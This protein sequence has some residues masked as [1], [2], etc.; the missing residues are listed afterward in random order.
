MSSSENGLE[1]LIPPHEPAS[2]ALITVAGIAIDAI[3]IIGPMGTRALDHALATRD[4]ERRLEF[5]RAV[6]AELQR[7]ADSSLT[8]GDVV[9]SDEFLAALARGQRVAAEASSAAKRTRL[10]AAVAS[11]VTDKTLSANERGGFWRYVEQYDDLHIWLLSFFSSP[12]DWLDAHG[13]SAAHERIRGGTVAEPLT[14][15]LG[16]DPRSTP[17]VRDAIEELQR[18]MMLGA[19]D[20]NTDRSDRGQFS[21]QTTNRGRRFLA[22]LH[23]RAPHTAETPE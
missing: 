23:E 8:V 5:D 20:L 13:L 12:I 6:V 2:D 17:T 16:S 11:T 21:P 4:R 22:F 10:A 18:D 15:A 3:P 1:P 19:F 14:A 9:S 7:Q